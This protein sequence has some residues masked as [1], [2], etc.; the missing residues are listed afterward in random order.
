LAEKAAHEGAESAE[1]T[2]L[3]GPDKAAILHQSSVECIVST[4]FVNEN[5]LKG[6]DVD[7]FIDICREEIL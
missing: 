2:T 1:Q 6:G 7:V 5:R 4:F 3:L